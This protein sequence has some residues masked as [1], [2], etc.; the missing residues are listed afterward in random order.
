MELIEFNHM[1]E[2]KSRYL[3]CLENIYEAQKKKKPTGSSI[4]FILLYK[5]CILIWLEERMP[6]L[7]S[8][9]PSCGKFW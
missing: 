6:M 8:K 2:N 5:K 9:K 4:F 7:L 1:N 3:Y